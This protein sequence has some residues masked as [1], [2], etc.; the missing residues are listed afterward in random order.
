MRATSLVLVAFVVL[1]GLLGC[2]GGAT[3]YTVGSDGRLHKVTSDPAEI[4][5]RQVI[6]AA[7][8]EARGDRPPGLGKSWREYW[9]LE[10]RDTRAKVL[11][12]HEQVMAYIEQQRKARGLSPL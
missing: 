7:D 4:F 3:L 8:R 2:G 6:W 12:T 10:S 11:G 5:R 9:R 1:I